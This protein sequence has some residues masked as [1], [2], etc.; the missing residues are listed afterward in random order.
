MARVVKDAFGLSSYEDMHGARYF[1]LLNKVNNGIN[2]VIV[3]PKVTCAFRLLPLVATCSSLFFQ[4]GWTAEARLAK[5]D[6][7][8]YMYRFT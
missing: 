3:A 7:F 5:V 6:Y 1:M 2:L 4:T 8:R